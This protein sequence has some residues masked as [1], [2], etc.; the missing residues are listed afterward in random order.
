MI[1]T[2]QVTKVIRRRTEHGSTF[3]TVDFDGGQRLRFLRPF[4]LPDFARGDRLSVEGV[5]LMYGKGKSNIGAVRVTVV[6]RKG[7]R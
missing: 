7:E 1:V 5:P 6:E 3:L 2:G 4:N